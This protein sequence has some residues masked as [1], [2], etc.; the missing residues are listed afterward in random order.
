MHLGE[1]CTLASRGYGPADSYPVFQYEVLQGPDETYNMESEYGHNKNPFVNGIRS[2]PYGRRLCQAS[3]EK[4]AL[5]D[6]E[7]LFLDSLDEDEAERKKEIARDVEKCNEKS[8][9]MMQA[10]TDEFEYIKNL[11]VWKEESL[12]YFLEKRQRERATGIPEPDSFRKPPQPVDADA[13]C[14]KIMAETT[15]ANTS[16]LV[17]EESPAIP[18][19]PSGDL[20]KLSLD[21]DDD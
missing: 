10:R 1:T 11:K 15:T 7:K 16:T 19:T 6:F 21:M 20:K 17:F 18:Y 2:V 4:E 12:K 9:R 3:G 8:K 14:A 5:T 13:I